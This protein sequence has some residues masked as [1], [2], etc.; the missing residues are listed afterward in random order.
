MNSTSLLQQLRNQVQE[1]HTTVDNQLAGLDDQ[2]LNFKPTPASWSI[3]ECL[4]HLN[5]YSRYYNPAFA[6]ALK[7]PQGMTPETEVAYSWLGAKSLDIVRP[8]NGKKSKTVK[9]MNPAGSRLS[10]AV[11]TEF[12]Q[13]QVRLLELLAAARGADLNRKAVPVEF[14]KLLKLRLGEALEFVV[15]H[16]TRHVQQALRVQQ[17][18]RQLSSAPTLAV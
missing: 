5:R 18:G 6:R 17:V 14:F 15:L 8:D 11:L 16:E 12:Q 9:H 7:Q 13:H 3:L 1:L 2:A 4:E 10:R